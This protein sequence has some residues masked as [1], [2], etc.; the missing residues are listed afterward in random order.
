MLQRMQTVWLLLSAVCV[1]LTF[2]FSFFSGMRDSNQVKA[3]ESVNATTSMIV[4]VL[5]VALA[6]SILID[7]FLYKNRKLQ[8]RIVLAA[9]LVSVLNIFLY[10]RQTRDFVDY[11]F[12]LTAIFFFAIPILLIL[13]ARGIYKDQ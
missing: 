9:I 6:S 2:K 10:F 12:D 7:I 11:K 13:A 8:M 1:F 5:S 4:L 3:L